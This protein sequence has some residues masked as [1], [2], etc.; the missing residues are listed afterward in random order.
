MRHL[1]HTLASLLPTAFLAVGCQP[2]ADPPAPVKARD[3]AW[4]RSTTD[5]IPRAVPRLAVT[6]AGTVFAATSEGVYA[7]TD[8]GVTWTR[9][10][11]GHTTDLAVG[12]NGEIFATQNGVLFRSLNNGGIWT[13]QLT[14]QMLYGTPLIADPSGEI[15]VGGNGRLYHSAA[16]ASGW[17]SIDTIPTGYGLFREVLIHTPSVRLI[18]TNGYGIVRSSDGGKTWTK[19]DNKKITTV[20]S[21]VSGLAGEIYVASLESSENSYIQTTLFHRSTDNGVT[22]SRLGEGL[23]A[24]ALIN[25]LMINKHGHLYAGTYEG[26][27][28]STDNGITWTPFTTGMTG[29]SAYTLTTDHDGYI[30]VG[31]DSGVYRSIEPSY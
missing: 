12:G 28:R 31:S 15:Y 7:T 17:S 26:V 30:Y 21:M 9:M 24:N 14:E 5:S 19:V 4:M 1:L 29:R 18:G 22:W 10:K 2:V 20:M 25:E 3:V 11:E 8:R 27:F 6:P 23:K 16:N 13:P